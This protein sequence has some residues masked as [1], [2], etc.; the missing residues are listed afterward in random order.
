[1]QSRVQQIETLKRLIETK[2]RNKNKD[3]W[4]IQLKNLEK[5]LNMKQSIP[6]ARL[7]GPRRKK[8]RNPARLMT[9]EAGYGEF[10]SSTPAFVHPEPVGIGSENHILPRGVAENME[11][12]QAMDKNPK[13]KI[14]RE[15]LKLALYPETASILYGGMPD[16]LTQPTNTY[17]SVREFDLKVNSDGTDNSG[18][19]S[20][21]VQPIF[22]SHQTPNQFQCGIVDTTNGWPLNFADGASYETTNAN[23]DP[24]VDPSAQYFTTGTCGQFFDPQ[25]SAA[26]TF[27]QA[28]NYDGSVFRPT[29]NPEVNSLGVVQSQTAKT[30]TF[31]ANGTYDLSNA[32]ALSLPV[33]VFDV[34]PVLINQG[35]FNISTSTNTAVGILMLSIDDKGNIDGVFR[36]TPSTSDILTG[37]L[38]DN[39]YRT[40]DWAGR[41]YAPE[42]SVMIDDNFN[43]FNDGKHT[44]VFGVGSANI[45][46][47]LLTTQLRAGLLITATCDKRL[48]ELS[49]SGLII[50]MRPIALSV[51]V[52][53]TLPDI[54]AGGN[55]VALSAPSGDI[56]NYYYQTAPSRGPYQNWEVLA[57]TNKGNMLYDD[58]LKKGCYVWTQPWD[59]NDTLMRTPT[60][61][62]AYDY[63]GVV[64]SGQLSQATDLNGIVNIGRVR[65]VIIYEYITDSRIFNPIIHP[66][67][68]NDLDFVLGY[69]GVLDHAMENNDHLKK[70]SNFISRGA[71]FMKE[72]IP[73]MIKGL[74]TA[75]AIAGLLI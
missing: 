7:R 63:Q 17:R 68:T 33:G 20:F 23:G 21:A 26:Y 69:L 59:K 54:S 5:K 60:E 41:I 36:N 22:G 73:T 42:Q 40:S 47:P 72:S 44:Y 46:P 39:I 58:N 32:Y 66:G 14:R 31:E 37:Y 4:T 8:I 18:R 64:V 71:R 51:L 28:G 56:K 53:C 35:V 43:L 30:Y 10:K 49:D 25:T 29:G 38:A 24:R 48:G 55:I 15:Y 27:Q 74:N 11:I 9:D 67:S 62:N 16:E 34:H 6:K 61:C 3:I 50:K 45:S 12:V 65:I 1:M 2:P 57:R 19:F 13:E 52:T 75:G 70:L